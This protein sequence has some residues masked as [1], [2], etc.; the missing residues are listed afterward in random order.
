[1]TFHYYGS[2]VWWCNSILVGLPRCQCWTVGTTRGAEQHGTSKPITRLK[3]KRNLVKGYDNFEWPFWTDR[4]VLYNIPTAGKYRFSW[5]FLF[6][7]LHPTVKSFTNQ[8]HTRLDVE[9][10]DL[11]KFFCYWILFFLVLAIFSRNWNWKRVE[12]TKKT[13]NVQIRAHHAGDGALIPAIFLA[14]C[15]LFGLQFV[16]INMGIGRDVQVSFSLGAR[17]FDIEQLL[18]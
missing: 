16:M 13:T 5:P 11:S 12:H 4:V 7:I 10:A 15:T 2:P 17:P 18:L 3:I 9:P 14:F 8:E 1:M 6:R